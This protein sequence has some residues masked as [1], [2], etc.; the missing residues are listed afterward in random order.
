MSLSTEHDRTILDQFSRQAVPFARR[1][2][3]DHQLIELLIE[4]S[5]VREEDRALDVACGPGIV[6]CALA[7]L[8]AQ[9]TGLDFTPAMIEQATTLQAEKRLANVTWRQGSAAALPFADGA[10]DLVVTRFSFHHFQQPRTALREMVRVCRPGGR[11]LVCDVAPSAATRDA[12]DLM[13]KQRDP[14]HTTALTEK[15]LKRLGAAEGIELQRE[16]RHELA[17]NV[18]D[19]LNDSFPPPGGAKAFRRLIQTDIQTEK[20]S[21]GVRAHLRDGEAWFYFPV[22][23]VAWRKA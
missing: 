14:S 8:A 11:I 19:L 16:A 21:L 23:I 7:P 5:G 12:Y 18:E 4:C 20:D 13:E 10:F 9:V 2:R 6:T 1:H 3:F 17:A 15:E 22:L